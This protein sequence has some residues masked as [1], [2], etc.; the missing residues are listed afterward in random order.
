[1]AGLPLAREAVTISGGH[2]VKDNQT[3]DSGKYQTSVDQVV[4]KACR[5]TA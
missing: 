5:H 2:A 3:D 4:D 1:M